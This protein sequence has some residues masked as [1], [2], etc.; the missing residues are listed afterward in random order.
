M[1]RTFDGKVWREF[2]TYN[3]LLNY[4]SIFNRTVGTEFYNSFF[5]NVA[6]NDNDETYKMERVGWLYPH[7]TSTVVKRTYKIV[8]EFNCNLYC[9]KLISDVRNWEYNDSMW[10][11]WENAF[12]E[13]KRTEKG[14][15]YYSRWGSIP[16]SAYPELRRGPWPFIHHTS[17]YH[18]FRHVHTYSEMKQAMDEDAKPFIRGSRGK[19]LPSAWDDIT[20][21]WRDKG[22]KSQ[23]KDKHQWEHKVKE[24]VKHKYGKNTY[25][26]SEYNK[27]CWNDND[28][29]L[30]A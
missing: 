11:A 21:D 10:K 12:R 27:K 24:K 18:F 23:N 6:G 7:Y 29:E 25:V 16:D 22:W 14:W 20:R 9:K 15:K 3:E 2:R 5:E 17:G 19:H 26:G 28:E 30:I 8:N 4:L 13:K 1:Y